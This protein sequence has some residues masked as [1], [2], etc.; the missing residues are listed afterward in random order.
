M[1]ITL[2]HFYRCQVRAFDSEVHRARSIGTGAVFYIFWNG[3]QLSGRQLYRP[4]FQIDEYRTLHHQEGLIGI[5]VQVPAIRGSHYAY[6]D[7]VVVQGGE[8]LVEID[9]IYVLYLLLNIY[10]GQCREVHGRDGCCYTKVIA[11]NSKPEKCCIYATYEIG[12]RMKRQVF[13]DYLRAVATYAVVVWHCVT[14]VY[15]KF[16][17]L[18]EWLPASLTVGLLVRWSVPVF[19]MISG[20]LLLPR[21]EDMGTFYKKRL[22]RILIPLLVWLLIYGCFKL[23][24]FTIYS[25]PHPTFIGVAIIE[26]FKLFLSNKLSYHFYFISIIL[27]LYILTPMLSRM[28]RALTKR[29]LEIF[30]AFGILMYSVRA[31]YRSFFIEDIVISSNLIYFILGYYLVTYPPEVKARR[32]LY[33]TA[34]MLGVLAF[35]LSYYREYVGRGHADTYYKPFGLVIYTLSA[36]L[37]VFFREN[38]KPVEVGGPTGPFRRFLTFVSNNSYGIFL[39]HPLVINILLFGNFKFYSLSTSNFTW[40]LADGRTVGFDMNNTAGGY[41]L[42]FLVFTIL[43]IFFYLVSRVKLTKY[44]T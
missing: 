25:T 37:F 20:A 41:V 29:H 17:P 12:E 8:D 28:V 21:E 1:I 16:G 14:N 43:L 5:R 2:L 39:A 23:Y 44:F 27:N 18:K 10:D 15:D 26:T 36:A 13:M 3:E 7:D 30:L 35:V 6:P 33:V 4:V 9:G 34:M 40:N 22:S 19:Y 11:V 38:I 24:F 42:S 31:F 32:I